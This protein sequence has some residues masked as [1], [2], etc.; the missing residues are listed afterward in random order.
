MATGICCAPVRRSR[1]TPRRLT[2]PPVGHRSSSWRWRSMRQRYQGSVRP[3]DVVA[4]QSRADATVL[5]ISLKRRPAQGPARGIGSRDAAYRTLTYVNIV[6]THS[7]RRR[8]P[9]FLLARSL[10]MNVRA[11]V[12]GFAFAVA[13]TGGAY[14]APPP[15][16]QPYQPQRTTPSLSLYGRN[17]IPLRSIPEMQTSGKH[18]TLGDAT[19]Q[20]GLRHK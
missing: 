10:P 6:D 2:D 9:S 13:V 5:A 20:A 8:D 7:H 4:W 14:A 3:Y 12:F 15:Q 19:P 11:L 18:P 1:A 16:Q 17:P